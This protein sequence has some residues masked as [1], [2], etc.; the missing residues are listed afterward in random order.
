MFTFVTLLSTY[1]VDDRSHHHLILMRLQWREGQGEKEAL[2]MLLPRQK[3]SKGVQASDRNNS[4]R[5]KQKSERGFVQKVF[6]A[7]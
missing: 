7:P 4:V 3:K 1:I 2:Q 6:S 5:A